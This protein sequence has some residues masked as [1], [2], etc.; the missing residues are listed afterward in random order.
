[1]STDGFKE[2]TIPPTDD[3]FRC[4]DIDWE[5]KHLRKGYFSHGICSGVPYPFPVSYGRKLG[6]I[7]EAGLRA[8]RRAILFCCTYCRVVAQQH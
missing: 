3:F 8:T 4:V 2:H 1:M 5:G 6:H 7:P